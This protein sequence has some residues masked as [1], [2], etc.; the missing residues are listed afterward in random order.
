MVLTNSHLKSRAVPNELPQ[1]PIHSGASPPRVAAAPGVPQIAIVG[2]GVKLPGNI[3]TT[4]AYWNLLV[5]GK[6]AQSQVPS[7][8][9]EAAGFESKSGLPCTA[10]SLRGYF[11]DHDFEKMDAGFFSMSKPEVEKLDPQ[12][13]ML[14][15][16]IWECM[17][18]GGQ[19]NWRGR[20]IGTYV[21]CFGEDWLDINA[22]DPQY[23]GPNRVLGY[24]DFAISNRAA[25]EYDLKGPSMTIRTA[26]SSSLIALHEACQGLFNGECEGA[27]VAGTSFFI[28]PTMT[29]ALSE[30]GILSP[31][32]SC[33]SFDAKADGYARGEA[34][35]CLYIKKLDDALRDGDPIRA[36]LRSTATNFDG[37]TLGITNP[38]SDS[39]ES[40]MRRAYEVAGLDPAVTGFVECHGT[41]TQVGDPTETTAVGRVF[42]SKKGLYITSVKPN[43]GHGEGAS[44]LNSLIKA[45]LALEHNTI[46]PNILF[47]EPNPKIKWDKYGFRV[48]VTPTPWPEDRAA[49]VSVNCFG[50]G[51][52]NAHAVVE[53]ARPHLRTRVANIPHVGKHLLVFSGHQTNAL[54]Q[55]AANVLEYVK[56]HPNRLADVAY[57]LGSRRDALAHRAFAVVDGNSQVEISPVVK[58]KDVPTVNFVFT[59]QGAQW[60]GM[61]AELMAG[62]PSFL[63][64]IREMD[65]CL[66]GLPHPPSWTMEEELLRS[67][68][69]SRIQEP[70][71][72]QPVCTAL[73]IGIVNL[74]RSWG[75]RPAAVVGHSSGEISAAYATGAL[76]L[77]MA[78]SIAYYRGQVTQQR[79][80]AGGMAAVGLGRADA[81]PYLKTGVV[82]ACENSPKNV[83]L[84]GDNDALD[85]VIDHIKGD[86]PDCFARRLRVE[87]AYHSHH[88]REIGDAYQQLLES[89]VRDTKPLVP[90]FSSVTAKQIKR[91]GS[92]GAAYWR[93]NLQNPVLFAPAVQL[94]LHAATS[95]TLFVE[96]GPHSALAGPLRD[97]FKSVQTA[98]SS[99]YVATLVRN[100]CATK[101][102][103]GTLGRLFQENYPVD[104]SLTTPSRT[105]LTDLPNYSWQHDTVYW[106]E[107]RITREWRLRKFP[108][109][110]LLGS[111]IMETDELEPTWRNMLRL[112][113]VPWA[114]DHKIADDVVLPGAAYMAMAIEA[115]RQLNTGDETDATIRQLDIKAALVLREYTAHEIITHFRPVRLTDSLNSTWWE[116]SVSSFNGSTWTKHC[117][118]QIRSGKEPITRME[119]VG[120]KARLVSTAGWYRVMQKVGLNYGPEFQAMTSISAEPG[121]N[122]AAA[123]IKNREPGASHYLL[124]PAMIDQVLQA[125]TVAMADG[126]TRQLTKLCVPRYIEQIYINKGAPE[127]RLGTAAIGSATGA[128]RGAATVKAG[129]EII[130]NLT[131]GEFTPLENGSSSEAAEPVPAAQLHWKPDINFADTKSLIRPI[132]SRRED[133]FKLEKLSLLCMLYTLTKVEGL[134][135][136]EHLAKFRAWLIAQ[137]DDAINGRYHHVQNCASLARLSQSRLASELQAS[138]AE[139]SLTPAAGVA[140]V[141]FRFMV[142]AEAIFKGEASAAELLGHE[143]GIKQLHN[144]F[145]SRVD[146]RE[147]LELLGHSNPT[148]RILEIGGSSGGLTQ[149][150]LGGLTTVDDER[151]Y[152]RYVYTDASDDAFKTVK[153][154]FGQHENVDFRVLDLTKDPVKQGFEPESFDLIIASNSLGKS[155]NTQETLRNVRKLMKPG[156]RLLLQELNPALKTFDYLHGFRRDW[157]IDTVEAS[158]GGTHVDAVQWNQELRDAGFTGTDAVVYDDEQPYSLT[159]TI[160]S[161]LD[162]DRRTSGE[163]IILGDS[164]HSSVQSLE[165]VLTAC[166]FCVTIKG[167][168]EEPKPGVDVISLLD[169]H[170]PFYYAMTELEMKHWQKYISRFSSG[171]G[172]L[173]VTSLAQVCTKDARYAT[174][175]GASRNIRSEL[176][177]DWATLEIDPQV[178]D[179]KTVANVFNRFRNRIKGPEFDPEWEYAV[180]NNKVMIPRYHW[181][182]MGKQTGNTLDQGPLK[183]EIARMGQLN[184]LQW[185]QD[186]PVQ[187]QQGEVEIEPRAVGM[188]FKDVLVAMGIVE[189]YKP[190][191]GIECSGVVSQLGPG[192]Q[193]LA[194]GDRVMT[195]GHGCFTTNFVTEASLATRLP[196]N[197]SFEEAATI[198]CVY[199]T[200]IHALINLGGLEEG[201]T[202]LVHSACGG[203]GIAAINICQMMGAKIY[204][205]VGN[206]DKVKYLMDTFGIPRDH[207]FNSRDSSFYGDLMNSTNGR[208]VDLVLNS[209]SGELLHVS[210]KCVAQ[211]GKM[212][213]IGKRDFIGK[214]QL[215]MDVFESNRSFH[216]IDMSQMAV[217]RPDKCQRILAQFNK[218][219]ESGKVKAISPMKVFHATDV[220]DAFRYMQKGQHIGKIVVTMPED[221][222]QLQI[223]SKP[224]SAKFRSDVSYLLVGGLGGLGRSVANW[225]IQNGARYLVFLSRSAGDS[226][227]DRSFISELEAQD[228]AVQTIKGTVTELADVERAVAEAVRPI[229]GVFL[230]TMV[231]RDR[232]IL[233]LTHEDWYEA[234]RP[235]VEGVINLHKA[236]EK[237]KLDFFTSFSSISYVVGQIGQTNYSAA[238]AFLA[239]FTQYRHSLGL[240]AAV[241][242]VGVMDD[243]GYV[244]ENQ[245]LLEQFKALGYHLLKENDLLQGLTYTMSHQYPDSTTSG[246]FVNPAEVVIGLKSTKSLT[247]P[248]SRALWKRDIRMAQAHL[249]DADKG[250]AGSGNE[251]FSQFIKQAH[252]DPSM[253]SVDANVQFLTKQIG[254]CVYNLMSRSVGELD[255][256]MTLAGLGVDSLVAIE[257]R[258]WWRHTLGVNSSVLEIMGAGSIAMLGKLAVE[259]IQKA[260][261]SE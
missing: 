12:S 251:D 33:K 96:I 104:L 204:A 32:G 62:Y 216:G 56:A 124:H 146:Y 34:I 120:D 168:V 185:I 244:V 234:A 144:F 6:S 111:R 103:L 39:H 81:T 223:T 59:G 77:E 10:K 29:L 54:Q 203:V 183:L 15:E 92:L 126:L 237:T 169:L 163:V 229:A 180:L 74:L 8:R 93:E 140:R 221:K 202:V 41:G 187:L 100:E 71:F 192:V 201:Q 197:M 122:K 44:G 76:T 162:Q 110:E 225:M 255:V 86:K 208:G 68:E 36:V 27:I 3:T 64:D 31:T 78:I 43:I 23:T 72:S 125:F 55:R 256:N 79:G 107:S 58:P 30:Q 95:N 85:Q 94:M 105:V 184:T 213:E 37:K 193:N 239:A 17:E 171:D 80:R 230:M 149:S 235:K 21:G 9:Y 159:T 238:N 241:L 70:E 259:G 150:I 45:V 109:H 249:K 113:N 200:A 246:H 89:I 160:F 47:N 158:L 242:N 156:A 164:S 233:Q 63:A 236:L 51:G 232:G 215:G 127:M 154:A 87:R 155:H 60:A 212:L 217:E 4:D 61:G 5:N 172:M 186:Q 240:P 167:L 139:L 196:E 114:R 198:P 205:T 112:D 101:S 115:V 206:P 254:E 99:T 199:A 142:K 123:T 152:I 173:W 157:W 170:K 102:L 48:P 137:R 175:I 66:K 227:K 248:N 218:Y 166:G 75:V 67:R 13:R 90:L 42:G 177:L 253:L 260:R 20:K 226:E 153:E 2:I 245:A 250:A 117:S 84:S 91:A 228:C 243:V 176:S 209:L 161:Q 35:N 129:D 178:F 247:D 52:A 141:I 222:S 69:E 219:Y 138:L 136:P 118:G 1:I 38:S 65:Q 108:P 133:L 116:F 97:T 132:K 11:L 49:R 131:G 57:T 147:F 211:F 143:H 182:D 210:W 207:I 191:L 83:T 181:V 28:S 214:G 135:A 130:L 252:N 82:I 194:V 151:R 231:L 128:I 14:L 257:I 119:D 18:S 88:M 134:D 148:M 50:V 261:S 7:N 190:G 220:I 145:G 16:V 106:S 53:S 179:A 195:I 174:T 40:L 24:G 98:T 258:N 46:P 25:Y 188:N 165:D 189:G 224:E 19:K 73:Q 26:C 22:K 121:Q